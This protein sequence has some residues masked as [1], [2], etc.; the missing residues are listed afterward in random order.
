M[1]DK[2]LGLLGLMRRA[3]AIELGE[4][5]SVLTVKAGKAKLLLLSSD[6]SDAAVR[7]AEGMCFGRSVQLVPVHYTREELG[8]SLGVKSCAMAA[9]TDIGFSNALMKELAKQ[10]P[11]KYGDVFAQVQQR[12]EKT[13]RRRKESAARGGLKRNV[14]RRSEV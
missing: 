13:Q 7:K 9:V 6:A 10:Q 2:A 5:N 14:K 8:L 11:E 1:D 12:L 4:D 3:G